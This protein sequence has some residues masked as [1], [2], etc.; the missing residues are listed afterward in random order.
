LKFSCLS[1][2][3]SSRPLALLLFAVPC[4]ATLVVAQVPPH[5]DPT[6]VPPPSL[7]TVQVQL[8]SNLDFAVKDFDRAVQLGKALFWDIQVGSDGK[9]AC[10]SCHFHAGSDSRAANQ[11]NPGPGDQ[12]DTFFSGGGGPNYLVR[13][14]DFPFR[15][16]AVPD[17]NTSAVIH[18]T[19]DRL[20][21]MGVFH[22]TNDEI[23]VGS[24]FD[25]G[26]IEL[27]NH[28]FHVGNVNTRRVE[29]RNTPTVINAVFL[30]RLFFD[31]R[32][33]H[34]FNGVNPFGDTDPDAK[35]L[36]K[37]GPGAGDPVLEER[38]LF[39]HGALASQSVGPPLS[40]FE[41]S[42]SGREFHKLGR[43][44]LSLSPLARQRVDRFDSVLGSIDR[45]PDANDNNNGLLIGLGYDDMIM[46]AFEE[47]LWGSNQDFG[48]YTQMER[49]FPLFW[50][51]AILCY[52]S[53]LV[54]DDCRYDQYM[55]GGGEGGS[56]SDIL[57]EQEK[58]GLDIFLDRGACIVCHSGPEFA[59]A[60]LTNIAL[61][62]PLERMLMQDGFA[63]GGLQFVTYPPP[64][65]E[66]LHATDL[67]LTID[68]RGKLIEIRPPG[69]AGA[70]LAWGFGYFSTG[71]GSCAPL[72]ERLVLTPGNSAPQNSGFEAGVRLRI[73]DNCS[74][75]FRVDMAWNWPGLPAG[76]YTLYIAGA[77]CGYIEM[78]QVKGPA[79]YDNGF[80]NIG[81]RQTLEDLGNGGSGPFGP[82]S[83]AARAKAGED[84]DGGQLQPPCG[85]AERIAVNGAFKTPSLRNIEL[86]GP[87]GHHGGF[88][89][90]EQVVD[91]YAGGAHFFQENIDD[92][93]PEVAGIGGMDEERKAA[94][95]AFLKTLTD[96]RVKYRRAPF[97]GPDLP[98][99]VGH[100]P[101]LSGG[102]VPNLLA[103]DSGVCEAVDVPLVL[104]KT[105]A[106]GAVI[107]LLPFHSTLLPCFQLLTAP[108]AEVTEGGAPAELRIVLSDRPEA[109]VTVPVTVT[110]TT[111]G[112]VSK[113]KL[114]FTPENWFSPQ[115][116]Q[117]CG[118]EDGL[119]DGDHS[120]EVSVGTSVSRDKRFAGIE[121]NTVS[122][123]TR[124]SGRVFQ[125]FDLQAESA[126]INSPMVR[127]TDA[128][129]SGGE[130]LWVPNGTGTNSSTT[131][132]SGAAALT[133][134]VTHA[135]DF[136]VW[137]LVQAPTTADNT[138]MA[139]LDSG[140]YKTWTLAASST[141]TWDKVNDSGANDPLKWTLQ[142]GS[143]TL[144]IR[145]R[146]DGAKLDRVIIT[147]NAAYVPATGQPVSR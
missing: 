12:F 26:D 23:N 63:E 108:G 132:N 73:G 37:Q 111:E 112:M 47:K 94:L 19:D 30:H 57:T 16:L 46:G 104:P 139:K 84:V 147:N 90:L 68:P 43:K 35:I 14:C 116:V 62:G 134:D 98:L 48:G 110:D 121:G 38:H 137:A 24:R 61:E 66:V 4:V 41:M 32:A 113:T 133:F 95:V 129:A 36:V 8:P 100:L 2:G 106:S 107:P 71:A 72:D 105:G 96:E 128:N 97:D 65:D 81:M 28:N 142:P 52:E 146:E 53:T 20:S 54:S 77:F 119:L 136:Y 3:L 60:T 117:V 79:V 109:N 67:P 51:L 125:T 9:T 92:L 21:S 122:Y 33:N 86:T 45:V 127:V 39:D 10:A 29:P 138:F 141:W 22:R 123:V 6:P 55:D 64:A 126:T 34:Y 89:T 11:V 83:L 87:Y 76:N 58:E 25:S 130:F 115:L 131:S 27:D 135:D 85:P 101:N 82:F 44:M 140:T 114:V 75:L 15:R 103:C 70:P 144:R 59:G 42:Y 13:S 99:V 40:D 1:R 120:F 124:D 102:L 17:D 74:K 69:G 56:N 143:H 88:S 18:D 31:G 118:C 78:G 7:K 91:F 80:Y 50:G 49:N 93:D 145:W 5:V